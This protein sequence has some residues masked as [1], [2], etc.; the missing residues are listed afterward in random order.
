MMVVYGRWGSV[1]GYGER[2]RGGGAKDLGGP[3]PNLLMLIA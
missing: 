2:M 3:G 1:R